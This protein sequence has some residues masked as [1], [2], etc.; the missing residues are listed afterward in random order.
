MKLTTLLLNILQRR[1]LERNRPINWL[2]YGNAKGRIRFKTVT[3]QEFTSDDCFRE[4]TLCLNVGTNHR[5]GM[6]VPTLGLATADT[7]AIG[8][9]SSLLFTAAW[10]LR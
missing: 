9:S 5:T 6:L 2:L 1:Q 3:W 4:S 7:V 10:V 8:Y